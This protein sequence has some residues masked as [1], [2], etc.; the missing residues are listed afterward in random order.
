MTQEVYAKLR[1]GQNCLS[2]R[3]HKH[4]LSLKE[5]SSVLVGKGDAR[6]KKAVSPEVRNSC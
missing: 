4:K 3:V 2:C 5:E 1:G 6:K